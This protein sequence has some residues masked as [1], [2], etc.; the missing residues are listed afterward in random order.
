MKK[1][2]VLALLC[3][4]VLLWSA[5]AWAEETLPVYQA[6]MG[7]KE[8]AAYESETLKWR[9][10]SFGYEDARCFLTS[11]WM[12]EPGKQIV[13]A[14]A[15]WEKNIQLPV[16][17]A[18]Q[19]PQATLVINGSGYVTRTFPE[20]P[21]NYPGTSKDYYFTPLGSLTVTNGQLF[22]HLEGVPYYGLTLQEDGLHMHVGEAP[23]EVLAQSPSQTW[24]FYV[25][26]PVIQ[27]HQ[28]IL[29]PE[30]KFSKYRAMRT[31][32]AKKDDNN[33]ILLTVTASG[34]CAGLTMTQCV[35]LLQEYFDPEWAYNLDGGPSSALIYRKAP[36]AKATRLFGGTREDADIMGFTELPQE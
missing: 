22:R 34:G 14:T 27:D 3:A 10:E 1:G 23:E 7:G 31:I 11:V 19:V 21:E 30:W 12:K 33:Y 13:K 9:I 6:T 36:G 20:I 32:I 35:R 24:S 15:E 16:N 17:M 8:Q 18:N 28:S 4:A 26:C 2:K 25:E 29:D 5:S